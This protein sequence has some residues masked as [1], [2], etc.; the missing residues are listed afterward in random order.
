MRRHISELGGDLDVG[1][2]AS[3]VSLTAEP[4]DMRRV[5]G[6]VRSDRDDGE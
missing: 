5:D 1:L 4:S 2:H 6:T 3:Q